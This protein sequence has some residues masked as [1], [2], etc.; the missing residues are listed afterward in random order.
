MSS[1][2]K[3]LRIF[4]LKG[5]LLCNKQYFINKNGLIDGTRNEMDNCTYFGSSLTFYNVLVLITRQF[6]KQLKM[7]CY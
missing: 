6:R 2:T 4:D 5:D 1:K 7:M 3:R